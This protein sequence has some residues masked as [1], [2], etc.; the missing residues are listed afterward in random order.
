MLNAANDHR[1]INEPD[2]RCRLPQHNPAAREHSLE[3]EG[4]LCLSDSFRARP[5]LAPLPGSPV[6]VNCTRLDRAH[7]RS[8][9]RSDISAPTAQRT[10]PEVDHAPVTGHR[11]IGD[12]F[13]ELSRES[14]DSNSLKVRTVQAS[15]HL[16]KGCSDATD[17]SEELILIFVGEVIVERIGKT[18]CVLVGVFQSLSPER[19]FYVSL[20]RE[21]HGGLQ[22]VSDLLGGLA[23]GSKL[24]LLAK[25][26]RDLESSVQRSLPID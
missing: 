8:K 1:D 21:E 22:S 25:E 12:F 20:D 3:E 15:I 26:P 17:S 16:E 10:P 9:Q 11:V 13:F 19:I 2:P 14:G 5:Q 7:E 24:V 23:I 6:R 18:D 4:E